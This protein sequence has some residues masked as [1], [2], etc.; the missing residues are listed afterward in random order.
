VIKN[1]KHNVVMVISQF[2]PLL[3]GAEIQAQRLSKALLEKGVSVSVLTRR[4]KG[5]PARDVVDDVPVYRA[6]LTVPIPFLWGVCFMVSV[7]IFLYRKRKEYTIIHCHILQEFQTVVAL[8]FKG[9][10]KKKVIVKMSSSGETSDVKL[11]RGSLVGKLFSLWIKKVDAVVSVCR[12]SSQDLLQGGFP[13][14]SIVEIPNGVDIHTFVPRPARSGRKESVITFVGRLDR[15]KGVDF[16]LEAFKRVL[17]KD[18]TSRLCI[19]GAGPDETLLKKAALRLN[20]HGSVDFKGRQEDVRAV[21]SDTDIFVLPT[22]SEG[23]SNVLLE[24]MACGLPI[25]AT[26]VGGNCDLISDRQNGMLVPPGD[27]HALSEALMEML[28]NRGLAQ[29]LGDQA[30]KTVQDHFSIECITVRYLQL[31]NSLAT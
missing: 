15:Y 6:I 31:Y 26:A 11:L 3:G 23:M 16:L 10:F 4:I 19:V 29:Q 18:N 25:V 12:Q 14:E 5:V 30:R 20:V 9:V 21:L 8:F 7:F 1:V 27:P 13:E 28:E 24:A 2:Y 17:S 22:L